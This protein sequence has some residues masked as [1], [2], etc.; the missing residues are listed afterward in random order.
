MMASRRFYDLRLQ[1]T[2]TAG[3]VH[4]K[5]VVVVRVANLFMEKQLKGNEAQII[6]GDTL[7]AGRR[8]EGAAITGLQVPGGL[9]G[10][11]SVTR[12]CFWTR[13]T[14]RAECTR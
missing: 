1:P 9:H 12:R 7:D 11:V 2:V 10:E 6:K 13:S 8:G 3:G 4:C 14:W 5:D